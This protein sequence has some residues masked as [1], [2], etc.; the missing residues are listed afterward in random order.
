MADSKKPTNEI[1]TAD[2]SGFMHEIKNSLNNIYLL[3]RAIVEG[4]L[5]G[6]DANMNLEL[7]CEAV[8]SVKNTEAEFDVY[9][10][11]GSLP[12]Q[13]EYFNVLPLI[14][15]I[16]SEYKV[17]YEEKKIDV[18]VEAH[19]FYIFTDKEKLRR[20]LANL[21]SNAIK[22]NKDNGKVRITVKQ[23]HYADSCLTIVVEDTGVGMSTAAL[24]KIG[25]PF[26]RCQSNVNGSGLG[27]AQ[28]KK[29]C[30]LLRWEITY[31][32]SVDEGTTV[33]LKVK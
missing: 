19:N 8:M 23:A 10:K 17:Y 16:V 29:I 1:V 5:S 31:K 21:I 13:K 22:Y 26:F 11:T 18:T 3:S 14:R 6:D 33:I 30:K 27:V 28:I 4:N 20:V 2:Y 25:T 9:R 15:S 24:Q 12:V 7:I 32:S